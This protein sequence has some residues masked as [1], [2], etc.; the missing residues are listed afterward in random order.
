MSTVDGEQMDVATSL[1]GAEEASQSLALQHAKTKKAAPKKSTKKGSKGKK[2]ASPSPS[3]PAA[4]EPAAKKTARA[5]RINGNMFIKHSLFVRNHLK[6]RSKSFATTLNG[7]VNGLH[8]YAV[9]DNQDYSG[10]FKNY[11]NGDVRLAHSSGLMVDAQTRAKSGFNARFRNQGSS[12]VLLAKHSGAGIYAKTLKGGDWA[13]HFDNAGKASIKL[14]GPDGTGIHSVAKGGRYSAKFEATV[15][16]RAK[17]TVTL[18]S[19]DGPGVISSTYGPKHSAWSGIFVANREIKVHLAHTK[20]QG[21]YSRSRGKRVWN[22]AFVHDDVRVRMANHDGQGIKSYTSGGKSK[23]WNAY[24]GNRGVSAIRLAHS[25]GTGLAAWTFRGP[26]WNAIFGNGKPAKAMVKIGHRSGTAI[27]S[28]TNKGVAYNALFTNQAKNVV[29]LA[30]PGGQ[31]IY[32]ETKKGQTF[33]MHIVNKATAGVEV[34][35]A[36]PKGEGI[37]VNLSKG[38]AA[39]GK[40]QT[41]KNSFVELGKGGGQ[42]IFSVTGNSYTAKWNS[43]IQHGVGKKRASKLRLGG[44]KGFVLFSKTECQQFA[45]WNSAFYNAGQGKPKVKLAHSSG[46]GL[47]S[48]TEGENKVYNAHFANSKRCSVKLAHAKGR[49]VHSHSEFVNA[50]NARFGNG[51]ASRVYLGHGGGLALKSRSYT[52]GWNANFWNQGK[53]EVKLAHNTGQ[54]LYAV[55]RHASSAFTA[56]IEAFDKGKKPSVSVN[57]GHGDGFGVW[58]HSGTKKGYGG[59]FSHATGGS[60]R[61]GMSG[62]RMLESKA[63][64]GDAFSGQFIAGEDRSTKQNYRVTVALGKPSGEGI[65]SVTASAG[66][67]VWNTEIMRIGRARVRMAQGTGQG[68]KSE[69]FKGNA[70]NAMFEYAGQSSVAL[71]GKGGEGIRST[72]RTGK[73]YNAWFQHGAATRVQLAGAKGNAL[74]STTLAGNTWNARFED[75]S[76]SGNKGSLGVVHPDGTV[77]KA[78]TR[79][80]TRFNA[81][82]K[83]H[84]KSRVRLAHGS[85]LAIDSVTEFKPGNRT[86]TPPPPGWV[87]PPPPPVIKPKPIK[88]KKVKNS[89]GK[90]TKGKSKKGKKKSKAREEEE[91]GMFDNSNFLEIDASRKKDRGPNRERSK[92]RGTYNARFTH[93]GR[94][95]LHV[96]SA[97]GTALEARSLEGPGN[98]AVFEK[99][100]GPTFQR[101]ILGHKTGMPLMVETNSQKSWVSRFTGSKSTVYLAGASALI[102]A[103]TKQ[104]VTPQNAKNYIATF[105]NSAAN[106]LRMRND[107][108]VEIGE[109]RKGYLYVSGNAYV[110]GS[111]RTIHKGKK[112]NISEQLENVMTENVAMRKS[113]D[114]MKTQNAMLMQRLAALETKMMK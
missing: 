29:K 107:G 19:A 44:E 110:A 23:V 113:L 36:G 47:Q 93:I 57:I 60:I 13:G 15:K 31:G 84:K 89:K 5:I 46:Q 4:A 37:M 79:G 2:I 34:K 40:F 10:V 63:P 50:Y 77:I 22:A 20:G 54:A 99:G 88:K 74:R 101:V 42:G 53:S 81:E 24:F 94:S 102:Y 61:L 62:G 80:G 92:P 27:A 55:N 85:G 96:A 43:V 7:A 78:L 9:Q 51:K 17:P 21:L 56:K 111:L 106:V 52:A 30:G 14:A 112:I 48:V 75:K 103:H 90:K 82:F 69:T 98:A 83:H 33:N 35:L 49:A 3:P 38:T 25:G 59:K 109:N 41:S 12:L 76:R 72:S 67:S 65:R 97:S 16:R 70:P 87:P 28:V 71:G 91:S 95:S 39:A 64:K 45:T 1:D 73:K 68:I 100:D 114:D 66:A 8:V 32:S 11:G 108:R 104:G 26:K 58:G 86:P 6:L 105:R 18:A